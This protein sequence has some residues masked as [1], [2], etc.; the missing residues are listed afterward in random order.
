MRSRTPSRPSGGGRPPEE[1]DGTHDGWAAL[2]VG[3]C[4]PPR[5]GT[6][7]R[8]SYL[9]DQARLLLRWADDTADPVTAEWMRKRARK[10]FE[11]A[12]HAD[13]PARYLNFALDAFNA[14]QLSPDKAAPSAPQQQQQQPQPK[15]DD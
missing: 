4:W 9:R 6:V 7:S 14:Q 2:L 8:T 10:L 13:D 5:A 11:L 3:P 1:P 12:E 15:S